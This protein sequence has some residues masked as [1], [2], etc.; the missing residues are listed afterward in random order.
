MKKNTQLHL[1]VETEL[2]ERLKKQAQEEGLTI[3]ESCRN[4]L[5]ENSRIIKIEMM[6]EKILTKIENNNFKK[7]LTL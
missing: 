2:F 6:V 5:K 7:P 4:K 1:V 3:S